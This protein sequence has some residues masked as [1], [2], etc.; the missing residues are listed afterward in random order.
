MYFS[1][2]RQ[3]KNLFFYSNIWKYPQGLSQQPLDCN[4]LLYQWSRNTS[5]DFN[6]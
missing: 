1:V 6:Q 4:A 2:K 5:L 3:W